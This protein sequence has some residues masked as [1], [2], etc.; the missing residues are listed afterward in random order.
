[1][2]GHARARRSL[3][4]VVLVAACLAS[5]RAAA[6]PA[7]PAKG[8]ADWM[9]QARWGT[10]THYL[11]DWQWGD[12]AA[13]KGLPPRGWRTLASVERWN[14]R[15]DRFDVEGLAQQLADARVPYHILTLGQNSGYYLAPNATYDEIVGVRPSRCARRDLVSD[16]ADALAKR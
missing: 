1:M 5:S 16:L 4:S 12:E 9:R 13:E 3:R 14:E 6:A 2:P 10:M 8:R 11:A 7:A 15:I